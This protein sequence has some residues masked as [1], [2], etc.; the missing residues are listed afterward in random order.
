MNIFFAEKMQ[1]VLTI[2]INDA[3]KCILLQQNSKKEVY[4]V[5]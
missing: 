4:H 5:D 2:Q 3:M 1:E